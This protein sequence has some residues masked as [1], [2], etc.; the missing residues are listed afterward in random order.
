MAT[1]K[2]VADLAG[3]SPAVV[4]YVLNKS[5]Y[6]SEEKRAAVLKAVEKLNYQPN[7]MGRS[8]KNKKT[9]NLGLICDDIRSELFPRL[10]STARDM[11]M[12]MATVCFYA[13]AIRMINF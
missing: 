8:L 4:S 11:P 2:D 5:N 12:R 3:V 6:V 7:Y 10:H 9:N 13:P 1:R